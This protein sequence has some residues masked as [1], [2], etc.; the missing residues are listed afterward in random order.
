MNRKKAFVY[1]RLCTGERIKSRRR[2][3]GISRDQV[4]AMLQL[5]Q[6]YYADIER[7]SCGMSLETAV[8]IAAHLEVT[9]DYLIHGKAEVATCEISKESRM[10]LF[11]LEHCG[12]DKRKMA[13]KLLKTYLME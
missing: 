12:S 6:K 7:G 10:I 2:E 3:L 9:L 5:S 13:V 11:Q 1:D 4:A 8:S